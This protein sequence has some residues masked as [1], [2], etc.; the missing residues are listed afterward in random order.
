MKHFWEETEQGWLE[1]YHGA[2]EAAAG[3]IY[4]LGVV[5]LDLDNPAHGR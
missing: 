2:K 1:I 5:M 3:P 4:R